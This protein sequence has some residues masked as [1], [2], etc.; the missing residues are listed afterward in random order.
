MQ[1]QEKLKPVL[2]WWLLEITEKNKEDI[3]TRWFTIYKLFNNL[4]ANILFLDYYFN[5]IYYILTLIILISFISIFSIP[6][7]LNHIDLNIIFLKEKVFPLIII[8]PIIIIFIYTVFLWF[9][10]A[11]LKKNYKEIFIWKKYFFINKRKSK[12]RWNII[13][14]ND[15]I[16]KKKLKIKKYFSNYIYHLLFFLFLFITSLINNFAYFIFLIFVFSVLIFFISEQVGFFIYNIQNYQIYKISKNLKEINNFSNNISIYEEQILKY[17]Q[18]NQIL[19]IEKPINKLNKYI[20]KI[21]NILIN[22]ELKNKDFKDIFD[23]KI[24]NYWLKKQI[25][26][27]LKSIKKILKEN[28]L[29]I[30]YEIDNSNKNIKLTKDKNLKANLELAKLR[31]EMNK[32]NLQINYENL[33]NYINKLNIKIEEKIK[34]EK[35]WIKYKNLK[36]F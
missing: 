31:L 8:I 11:F 34:K 26:I 17:I 4:E 23:F 24:Y 30:K 13:I 9:Y 14:I 22:Q 15:N 28:I 36:L 16:T 27:P 29:K 10:S 21:E 35:K 5:F 32:K 19:K 3:K 20:K 2:K 18:N 12:I 1:E 7:I 33:G 25:I 6:F